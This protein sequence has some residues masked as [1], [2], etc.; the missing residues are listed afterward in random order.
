MFKLITTGY[1]YADGGAMF[2]AIPKVTWRRSYPV[3][4][5]NLCVLAMHAG[6]IKTNDGHIVVVDPGIGQDRLKDTP[7]IYYQF[8]DTT[9]ICA[10][11]RQTGIIPEDVTDVIFTHLHFDH[12]GAAVRKN[13]NNVLEPVFPNAVHWVSRAQY[14]CERK[15]HPLEKE[16][17]LPGN[18]EILEKAGLLRLIEATTEPFDSLRIQLYDGHTLGQIAAFVKIYKPPSDS[19]HLSCTVDTPF[20]KQACTSGSEQAATSRN[21]A[22]NDEELTV[23][24]PGDIIPLASHIVPERISAY[25]LYPTLS[26][27][28][29]VEILEKAASNGAVLVY[30]HDTYTPCSTIKKV[31]SSYKISKKNGF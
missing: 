30:Y 15:P 19:P 31:G 10:A 21:T 6:I 18:T 22:P 25:D 11:L 24:F 13:A 20:F 2:G 23:I 5:R 16:S 14:E 29:K 8:H 1:F 12:C 7:A 9:D 3:N 26:Y 27:N 4:E 17:F 28:G